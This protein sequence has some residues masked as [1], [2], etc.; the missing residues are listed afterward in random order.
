MPD[1][2]R[3]RSRASLL[4]ENT[5]KSVALPDGSRGPNDVRKAGMQ[6]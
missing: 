3:F 6:E 1:P 2:V 5:A 4:F